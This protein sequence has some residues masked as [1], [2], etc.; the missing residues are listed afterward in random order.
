MLG[1]V[2]KQIVNRRKSN[3]WLA[4]ELLLVFCFLWYMVDYFFVLGCNYSTASYR[5]LDHTYYVKM[6]TLPE[7]HAEYQ[8]AENDS[9]ARMKH[10]YRVIDRIRH[11]DGVE[12]VGLSLSSF[13]L[14]GSGN[15]DGDTFRNPLDTAAVVSAQIFS[16]LTEGDYFRVFRHSMDEGDKQVS[17]ADFDWADPRA[18][19][20]SRMA[21]KKLF[22][23]GS[24]VGKEIV[25]LWS[26]TTYR[27]KGVIDD[28]KRF[29]YERPQAI[30][31]YAERMNSSNPRMPII[32][33]RVK[34]DLPA[35]TFIADFRQTMSGEL[36]I[37]NFYL[38]N[39]VSFN[40][41]E[42]NTHVTFGITN[43]VR[44][45]VAM[46]LFFLLNILLCVIGTF[47][48]RVNARRE[49]IGIRRAMGSSGRDILRL[50]LLEGVCLLTLVTLLAMLIE[51]QFVYAGLIDTLGRDPESA[52]G[53]LPDHTAV[54][55]VITNVL[56]WLLMACIVSAGI[57]FPAR[58]AAKLKPVEALR[59]E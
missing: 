38:K 5:S 42:Q 49:E 47:W 56:T 52:G 36:R 15:Y 46:M 51:A 18:I 35:A 4:L 12:E 24:A 31:F 54:R 44:T 40:K 58:A 55:F 29:G 27:V 23:D 33:I 30:A 8:A 17:M 43:E 37:G 11:Y 2:I 32:M 10:I 13:S 57:W 21:E 25:G 1:S 41:L 3:T 16:I 14:P 34:D 28:V 22:P 6:A 50:L 7:S 45:R 39:I 9:V 48:Y 19:V 59:D 53:Y 26:K 20:I